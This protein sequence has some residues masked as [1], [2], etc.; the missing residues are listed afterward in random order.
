MKTVWIFAAL[1]AGGTTAGA[2]SVDISSCASIADDHARLACYDGLAASLHKKAPPAAQVVAPPLSAAAAASPVPS[3]PA[4]SAP[5][6]RAATFGA[7]TIRKVLTAEEEAAEVDEIH[8]HVAAVQFSPNNRFTVTLDNGQ[9]WRQIEA[10]TARA[11]FR[12]SGGDAVIVSK[13]AL[14][15]Y[16]LVVEG[17]SVLF[18]VRRLQ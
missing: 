18:K 16:N 15:S 14:G 9:V 4:T 11:R 13:G 3:S 8:A 5:A 17:R 6:S 10:D 7:E 1:L 12:S 2:Q